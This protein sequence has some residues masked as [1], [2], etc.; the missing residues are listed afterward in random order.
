MILL[1]I[2]AVYFL[3]VLITYISLYLS[4]HYDNS[5]VDMFYTNSAEKVFWATVSVGSWYSFVKG[6][7]EFTKAWLKLIG[8]KNK[9]KD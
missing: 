1:I 5:E 7:R 9:N 8:L 4:D 2:A 6:H 3:G